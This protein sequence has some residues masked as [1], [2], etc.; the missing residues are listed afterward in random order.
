MAAYAEGLN[1]LHHAN[2]GS[3]RSAQATPRPRRCATREFYQYDIDLAEVAEVWRR[4]QRH[5]VVAARPHRRRAGRVARPR[6]SSPAACPTPARAAGPCI[7]AIDEGVPAPVLTTALFERFSSRGEADFADQAPLGDAQAVR[8][9]RREA[10]AGAIVTVAESD[11]RLFSHPSTAPRVGPVAIVLFGAAGDLAKRK[12]LPG[13]YHLDVAGL[14]PEEWRL[15][16]SSRREL[17]DDDFRELA[18]AAIEEF[19][20]SRTD[21]E[22]WER[23][24]ERLRYVGGGFNGHDALAH[25][26][27]EAAKEIG[28][29]AA[30]PAL[31]GSARGVR[32][33]RGARRG[34]PGQRRARDHREAVRDR[35]RVRPRA[36]RA[37]HGVLDE[38]QS[39]G[40][41]T[42]SARRRCRTSWRSG[43]RTASSS[44]CGTATSST[45]CRSTCPRLSPIGQRASFYEATGA[46]RDVVVTH[47]FQVLGFVAMDLRSR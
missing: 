9:A 11:H 16:G 15:I 17:S 23:F 20:R 46:L 42:S 3:A 2:A 13:L 6:R 43:S 12:L 25:A 26:A 36:E 18:R 44:R 40:S 8:R 10:A 34:R 38:E 29:D 19:G 39:S 32:R 4:G 24:A 1:I 5:R 45:T 30:A 35:P 7:A 47:L 41:T 33:H 28:S 22:A 21:G 31:R 14:L 27:A 37:I